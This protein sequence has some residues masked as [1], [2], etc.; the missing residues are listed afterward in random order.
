MKIL[1]AYAT[2]EGHTRKI[3][4]HITTFLKER[5]HDAQDYDC[6]TPE[7]GPDVGS[8][9]AFVLAGS[10]HQ[11]KH[12]PYLVDYAKDNLDALQNKPSALVSVSLSASMQ[13]GEAAAKKYVEEFT[14][15]TG[16][17]PQ[18][19]HLAGGAIRFVEYDFYKQ[20]TIKYMVLKGK[21]MPDSSVGNPEYTD[22]GALDDFLEDFLES[23]TVAQ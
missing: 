11:E 7:E 14:Q 13:D 6:G 5:G 23:L 1:I 18:K 10:I 16:W 20:F 4:H 8:F 9:D 12:Q 22:W 21:E 3:A 15:E 17:E 2:T 19:V